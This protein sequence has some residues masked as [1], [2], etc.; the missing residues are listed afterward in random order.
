[1]VD[2]QRKTAF[3]T[4]RPNA[5]MLRIH[6]H[7]EN[8]FACKSKVFKF[9]SYGNGLQ[10]GRPVEAVECSYVVATFLIIQN[11]VLWESIHSRAGQSAENYYY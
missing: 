3:K 7:I 5:L 11:H 4:P 9:L 10:A 6:I 2:T 8:V 1:M